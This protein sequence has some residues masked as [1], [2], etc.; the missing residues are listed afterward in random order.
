[1]P[2]K[3]PKLKP[4][5]IYLLYSAVVG[6]LLVLIFFVETGNLAAKTGL[7]ENQ[8]KSQA[9]LIDSFH[10]VNLN[11]L[12]VASTSA[13]RKNQGVDVATIEA[14]L[15]SVKNQILK[16]NFASS[17][18]T[19]ANLNLALNS[20]LQEK[21][22][23]DRIASEEAKKKAD[24]EAARKA[25]QLAVQKAAAQ[26]SAT[27]TT[28]DPNS[29][30]LGYTRLT[31]NT[32]NGTFTVNV[33]KVNLSSNRVYID[34][35]NDSDCANNC[36]TMPLSDYISRDGGLY[37]MNGTYFCPPDYASCSGKVGSYDFPI[38]NSRLGHWLN[39][40]NLFWVNRAMMTF[41]PGSANFYP[42]SNT[43]PTGGFNG[44][45][46]SFPG[47]VQNG[48]DITGQYQ[49]TASQTGK[50]AK[51]GLGIKGNILFMV[52]VSSASV[53]DLAAIFQALGADSAINIDGGGSSAMWAGGYKVG[54]GRLLPNA[55]IIK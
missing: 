4:R 49:L 33:I 12:K 35:A 54:P 37:G 43:A 10:R 41:N 28:S 21:L 48:Q 25:A 51:G 1:M 29:L 7:L 14:E 8:I 11:Y 6:I 31:L 40:G 20:L 17:S 18:A 16:G 24:L 36:P 3:L 23:K 45:I 30:G 44:A 50:G 27:P 15:V 42:Q 47:L 5:D 26:T 9:I 22:T 46:V 55:V 39:Q 38:F 52:N 53:M 13:F 32:R 34:S 19:L 2:F